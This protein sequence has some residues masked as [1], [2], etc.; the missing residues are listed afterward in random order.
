MTKLLV[1][2]ISFVL[3]PLVLDQSSLLAG[4]GL[5]LQSLALVQLPVLL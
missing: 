4:L 5:L 2:Y 3:Q 1:W